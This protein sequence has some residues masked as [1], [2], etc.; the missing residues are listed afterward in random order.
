MSFTASD[1]LIGQREV[2]VITQ[3]L[4]NEG[5][6]DPIG[7]AINSAVQSVEA[8]ISGWTVSED[9]KNQFI[10]TIALYYLYALMQLPSNPREK[11]YEQTMQELRDI[12][13]GKFPNLAA[14]TAGSAGSKWGGEKNI[15]D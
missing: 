10:R 15:F 6:P 3:T 5:N 1:L 7:Q 14:T 4:T 9:R 11:A 12:R 13:D 8:Y 2:N